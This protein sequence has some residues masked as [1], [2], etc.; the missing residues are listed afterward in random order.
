VCV[1]PR[2]YSEPEYVGNDEWILMS[3]NF[4]DYRLT[5]QV[6]YNSGQNRAWLEDR[7]PTPTD[8]MGTGAMGYVLNGSDPSVANN[9]WTVVINTVNTTASG[10]YKYAITAKALQCPL[11][12]C[13]VPPPPVSDGRLLCFVRHVMFVWVGD[14]V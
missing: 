8:D 10:F 13:Y 1:T 9:S 5:Y 6:L 14:C 3:T 2:R 12:G 7:L 4:T 11:Q